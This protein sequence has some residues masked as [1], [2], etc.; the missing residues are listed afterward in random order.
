MFQDKSIDLKSTRSLMKFLKLAADVEAHKAI[1]ERWGKEP[2]STFLQSE[3]DIPP[4]LQAPLL[5]LTAS[6][7]PP[8]ETPT[9]YA[10]PRIHRHLTSIGLFGQGFNAII[11]KWGGLAEVA[12]VA[13]RASAVGGGVYVLKKGIEVIGNLD[14]IHTYQDN[15]R[16]S[17]HGGEE[18][19]TRYLVGTYPHLVHEARDDHQIPQ[20]GEVSRSVTIVSSSLSSLF[21]I[22]AEG[23][24][25]PAGAVVFFATGSLPAYSK[26]AEKTPPVFLMVHSSDTG[27][28]PKG[29]CK[30]YIFRLCFYGV[31]D[32]SIK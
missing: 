13:C 10:L 2:F 14:Q 6:M 17:L 7:S 22:S 25:S 28:C 3:F 21:P 27:E 26:S 19:K 5:A 15:L 24:S 9:K 16:L 20:T 32:E 12:Q 4:R 30:Y 29:Q 23:A 18:I 11:P 1:L 8:A 31:H